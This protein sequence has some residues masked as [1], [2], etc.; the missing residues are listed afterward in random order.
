MSIYISDCY[1]I[2]LKFESG[3]YEIVILVIVLKIFNQAHYNMYTKDGWN[4]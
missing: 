3:D 1:I 2:I 4:F